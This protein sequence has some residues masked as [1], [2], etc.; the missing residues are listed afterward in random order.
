MRDGYLAVKNFLFCFVKHE[1][2]LPCSQKLPFESGQIQL[3]S[4]HALTPCPFYIWISEVILMLS[5]EISE[6][7]SHSQ[8]ASDSPVSRTH[9]S[10]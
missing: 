9:H 10:L 1:V 5:D 4:V 6:R 7:I 3:N 8:R 2:S